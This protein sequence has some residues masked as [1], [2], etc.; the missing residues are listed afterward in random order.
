MKTAQQYLDELPAWSDG[1]PAATTPLTGMQLRIFWL[2]CAGKFFEG[3]VVFMTG[4]ALP[5]M[6]QEFGLT[7]AD[8]GLVTAASLAGILLGASLLGGLADWI[9]RKKLFVGEMVIFALFLVAL[10][11]APNF[12][13]VVLCLFGA[14]V[15][16]G[17]DYPT[18]HLIISESI[19]TSARGRL[20]LMAF[21]FQAVGALVGSFVGFVILFESSDLGDWRWM[22]AAAVIPALAVIVGRF[23]VTESPQWLVSRERIAEAEHEMRRLLDRKPPYPKSVKLKNPHEGKKKKPSHY[24]ALFHQENRRATILASVPWFLQDLSTYGIGIFT[25]TILAAIIGAEEAGHGLSAI[26]H[27]DMLAAEGSAVM[28]IFFILGIIAAIVLVDR[29]GR[30]RLQVVGFIGCAV[31]LALAAMSVKPGGGNDM[32]LLFAG[33][34]LFYFMTNLGPNAMTYLIAG[35]VFP[36]RLRGKGAGFAAS[37]AKVG[38]VLTAFLFPILLTT[39]GTVPLLYLLVGSSVLGAVVT[40]MSAIETKGLN[41][42]VLEGNHPVEPS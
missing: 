4:V 37:I 39:I 41:L 35:E 40:W 42:E 15:A 24:G 31:G 1:T 6:S 12:Q 20:V 8:K 30:M 33:F 32:V 25:P 19:P 16:L 28:N 10:V 14:G 29:V 22:Y 7:A 38:A 21:A 27:N 3:M 2:A 17:C 13:I 18:A 11:F 26:I 23:F 34:I 36:T 5:L 9:G